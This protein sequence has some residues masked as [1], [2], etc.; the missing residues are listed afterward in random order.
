MNFERVTKSRKRPF[1]FV[2]VYILFTLSSFISFIFIF[3]YL[4]LKLI[5]YL[6]FES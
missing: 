1:G 2:L 4:L 5:V 3:N 6:N